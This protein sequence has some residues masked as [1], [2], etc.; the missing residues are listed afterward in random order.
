ML[1][2]L[3]GGVETTDLLQPVTAGSES[4]SEIAAGDGVAGIDLQRLLETAHRGIE[5][6][7]LQQRLA[8]IVVG[9]EVV[10]LREERFAKAPGGLRERAGRELQI[11]QPPARG[12]GAR[13]RP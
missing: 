8:E 11:T 13:M 1:I 4:D 5:V 2:R 7:Q 10:G 9:A 6:T 12:G 3:A